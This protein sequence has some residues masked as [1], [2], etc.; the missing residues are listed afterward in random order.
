MSED[1][2]YAK[3]E[4]ENQAVYQSVKKI[5]YNKYNRQ[6]GKGLTRCYVTTKIRQMPHSRTI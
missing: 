1:L 4:I 5:Q 6:T 2:K 3:F